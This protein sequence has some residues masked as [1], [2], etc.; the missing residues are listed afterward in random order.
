MIHVCFGFHDKNGTYSKFAGTTMLSLF[1]NTSAPVTVHILHDDT[2]T[3]DNRD[4]FI[5]LAGRYGQAVEFY[6]VEKICPD[7]LS[8]FV[9]LTPEIKNARVSVGTLYRLLVPQIIP[10]DIE[11]IIYL[12]SD[13]VVNIDI[14]ELW[15]VELGEKI[16]AGVPEILSFKTV[17]NMNRFFR[18]C[19]EGF[20]KPE[21]Y[22]NAGVLVMNLNLLRGEE[23]AIFDGFYF[24][25]KYRQRGYFDQDILNYCFTSRTLKLPAKFNKF[26]KDVRSE[27]EPLTKKI[28]HYSGGSFGVGLGLDMNDALN[29]LWMKYFLK[30]PWFDADTIGR[31]FASMRQMTVE[32][33]ASMI[34]LSAIMSG[35]VRAFVVI[36]D[37]LEATRQIFAVRPDEKIISVESSESLPKVID[38]MKRSRGKKIFFVLVPGF[39]LKI[40][41]EAGFV[42]GADFL[43][44][45]EF[46]SE[47]HGLPPINSYPLVKAM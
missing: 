31:L 9:E 6:N 15:Q 41:T 36:A 20:V 28:Y 5:Y 47:A 38:A 43:N 10:S 16:L 1:E 32:A 4:K 30:T 42:Y 35:K 37:N 34:Q 2:L 33:K 22:F 40:L 25:Q 11:K 17:G 18:L 29:R 44:G 7:K 45:F 26:T 14:K 3:Q 12:D 19:A 24:T 8:A 39:P 46:L 23:A 21:D 27:K 13:I